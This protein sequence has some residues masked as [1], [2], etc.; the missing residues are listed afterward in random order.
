M[1]KKQSKN[2]TEPVKNAQNQDYTHISA[3]K[4][5]RNPIFHYQKPRLFH[6][7]ELAVQLDG[8]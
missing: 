6:H 5:V 1:S 2:T 7:V 3:S 8:Y 4:K